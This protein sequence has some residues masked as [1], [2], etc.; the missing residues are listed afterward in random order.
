LSVTARRYTVGS[1]L[2]RA[3]IKGTAG[4]K[5]V[6]RGSGHFMTTICRIIRTEVDDLMLTGA[7]GG[8]KLDL[9]H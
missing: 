9:S 1:Y 7:F 2:V 5:R 4:K 3:R 6:E 8:V